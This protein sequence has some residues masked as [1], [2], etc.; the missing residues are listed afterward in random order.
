M[1]LFGLFSFSSE[2]LPSR[3]LQITDR[4]QATGL[5]RESVENVFSA[6][7]N[8]PEGLLD[9]LIAD[10]RKIVLDNF[11][12]FGSFGD[13]RILNLFNDYILSL[14]T[15]PT[16]FEGLELPDDDGEWPG[17]LYN[18]RIKLREKFT[19]NTGTSDSLFMKRFD[20]TLEEVVNFWREILGDE[21]L[22][23]V[24][25]AVFITI[26][27]GKVY[28]VDNFNRNLAIAFGVTGGLVFV[29][30]GGTAAYWYFYIRDKK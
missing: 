24:V 18:A 21:T 2:R 13:E 22:R 30:G 15:D 17:W 23:E 25:R 6:D 14:V 20:K 10:T 8:Q 26:K 12:G 16:N 19:S 27:E 29:A 28:E 4:S 1:F 3:S 11:A 7:G 9:D 5:I